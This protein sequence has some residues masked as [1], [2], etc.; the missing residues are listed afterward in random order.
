MATQITESDNWR[1]AILRRVNQL[2]EAV[3]PMRRRFMG[4]FS[5]SCP[6]CRSIDFRTVEP[7][8]GFERFFRPLLQTYRCSLCGHGFCLI[9]RS[10][11]IGDA[12]AWNHP[13][14]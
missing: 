13:R 1:Q 10:A 5:T 9:R 7:Q 6:W 14:F 11:V 8:N 12:A 4:W 3:K 2:S